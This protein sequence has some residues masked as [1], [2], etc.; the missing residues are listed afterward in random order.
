MEEK[1][2]VIQ[3]MSLV[4]KHAGGGDKNVFSWELYNNQVMEAAII[5][6]SGFT[7]S[8]D[9]MANLMKFGNS[10]YSIGKCFH[11]ENLYREAVVHRNM[12]ACVSMERY[13]KREP[14]IAD[15]V[16]GRKRGRLY[17]GAETVWNGEQV[18]VNSFKEDG[19]ANACSYQGDRR[20]GSRVKHK[21]TISASDVKAARKAAKMESAK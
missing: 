10:R 6:A 12:S 9:D 17:V 19:R 4:W 21:Y 7:W 20:Y 8:E 11:V 16:G 14:I 3:L 18:F 2:P 1:T 5:A 15:N 13:L